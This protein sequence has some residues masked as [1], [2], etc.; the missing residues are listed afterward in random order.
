M[1]T[2]A[3][4]GEK[5]GAGKSTLAVNVAAE[6]AARGRNVLLVDADPQ[7]TALVWAGI[8]AEAGHASPR[9]L[10]LGDNL[11]AELPA[12]AAGFT[13]TV[14]DL[15]GRSS[16]RTVGALVLSDVAIIPCGPSPAD[17]WALAPTVELVS[18]AREVRAETRAVLVLNRA[19]RTSIGASTRGAIADLG[20]PVLKAAIGD[21]VAFREALA[22]GQGVTAYASASP[23][24]G[25]VRALVD[26]LEKLARAGRRRKGA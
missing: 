12:L 1:T 2:I 18:E 8:A 5:G 6:L 16:K 4:L 22:A 10:A 21:R 9:T 14:I 15:P 20:L 26:E 7:G 17:A 19:D 24:A 23:A 11:R 3:F 25:E 13:D